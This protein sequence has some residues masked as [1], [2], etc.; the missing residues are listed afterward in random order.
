MKPAVVFWILTVVVAF[1]S[2]S[3]Q[4]MEDVDNAV[5]DLKSSLDAKQVAVSET[6]KE[7]NIQRKIIKEGRVRFET[8]DAVETGVLIRKQ[9]G[10]CKGYISEDNVNEYGG[11]TEYQ[12]TVR[13]PAD[14]F[15][16]LLE[17][18]S[19]HAQKLDSK[20][21]TAS[22]V[23]EEFIDIEARLATKK[24][25]EKRYKEL[26]Q[27][28]VVIDDILQ[29]ENQ[30]GALRGDIESVE[31]RLKY[32]QDRV[33]YSTL[34]IEYYEKAIVGSVGFGFGGKFLQALHDGWTNILWFV[35]GLA[36]LWSFLLIAVVIIFIFRRI[37]R[38]R[39]LHSL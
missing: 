26:L 25:L 2:C 36:N 11:N 10:D 29:I 39:K 27:R 37:R 6:I 19:Q 9:V 4:Q 32:M 3:K 17:N 35:I 15:E 18:I 38:K 20:H 1:C 13:I 21:V 7:T 33:S 30:I 34:T 5:F 12:M 31:G 24:E 16:V 22:D 23:T 28:A 8:S 14:R